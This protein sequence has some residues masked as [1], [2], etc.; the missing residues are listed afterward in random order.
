MIPV[1]SFQNP[2]PKSREANALAKARRERPAVALDADGPGRQFYRVNDKYTVQIDATGAQEY[3][4]CNCLAASP[5]PEQQ[6]EE[7][8]CYHEGAV[9]IHIAEQEKEP[10]GDGL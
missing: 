7:S 6:R 8:P 9:L 3:I 4:G 1:I 5:P 2:L 10:D